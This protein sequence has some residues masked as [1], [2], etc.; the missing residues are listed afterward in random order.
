MTSQ[1]LY[2]LIAGI[3]I[4]GVAGYLGSL[5]LQKRMAL[6]AGPLGHLAFPGVALALIYGFDISLGAFPFII[7]GIIFIWILE[8]RTKIPTDALT[9]VVFASGIAVSFLFLPIQEAEEALV[10]NI[11][12][13]G[14]LEVV[15]TILLSLF[16]FAMVKLSIRQLTIISIS[17]DLAKVEGINIKKYNFIFLLSI[18]IIVALGVK[19]VGALLTAALVSIPAATAKNISWS[20]KSYSYLSLLFGI[21]AAISGIILHE[22]TNLPAGILIILTSAVIF[23]IS[24]FFSKK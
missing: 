3:F 4:G 20:M 11:S 23:I 12:Y 8:N 21:L 6:A 9:A 5:M 1:L 19:L 14:L 16:V 10:G 2:S 13:I 18:A 24:I 17:E 15:I 7:L 22:I